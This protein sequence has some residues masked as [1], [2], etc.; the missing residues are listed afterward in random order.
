MELKDVN[1]QFCEAYFTFLTTKKKCNQNGANKQIQRLKKIINYGIKL[2]YIDKNK[3]TSYTLEFTPV[4]KIA[5]TLDEL[6]R[7]QEL[8]LKREVLINVRDV[9]LLQCYTGLTYGDVKRLALTDI[10]LIS[11]NEYWIKHIYENRKRRLAI[12]GY[13]V[14]TIF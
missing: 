13:A 4:N 5:L 6:K 10:Q 2:G 12:W 7:L 9:F 11:E 8:D 3:L 14:F 1:Y